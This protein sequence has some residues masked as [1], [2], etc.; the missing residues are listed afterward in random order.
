M[1][2]ICQKCEKI[3][4]S[5][6][7][8][9]NHFNKCKLKENAKKINK[10]TEKKSENKI[11]TKNNLLY[12]FDVNNTYNKPKKSEILTMSDFIKK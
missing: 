2:L 11:I 8:L 7:G 3:C 5:K 6:S 9:T 4:K 12:Y 10:N 1:S